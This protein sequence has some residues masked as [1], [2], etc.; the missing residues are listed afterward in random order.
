MLKTHARM[1]G[2]WCLALD[3]RGTGGCS[4][5]YSPITGLHGRTSGN[6]AILACL[7]FPVRFVPQGNLNGL[8]NIPFPPR[9]TDR[10]VFHSA[11]AEARH[12]EQTLQVGTILLKL[13]YNA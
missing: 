13:A 6:D 1:I 5:A 12:A 7:Q 2:C 10:L 3:G 9:L 11:A 4:A 8:E